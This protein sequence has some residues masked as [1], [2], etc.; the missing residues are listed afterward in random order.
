MSD[1]VGVEQANFDLSTRVT[2]VP[3]T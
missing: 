3:T 1:N 2:D